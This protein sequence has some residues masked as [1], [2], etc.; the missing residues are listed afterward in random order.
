[1]VETYPEQ[2]GV[3]FRHYAAKGQ[4]QSE[5]A[6]RSALAAARQG[7]GWEMLEMACTNADRLTEAGLRSM[8][9]QLRLDVDRFVS[10]LAAVEVADVL[11][12]DER[13]A[14]TAQVTAVPAL[15][16][17]GTRLPDASTFD[18][19]DAAIKSAIK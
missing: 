5:L 18:A 14:A 10:D 3:S 12:S 13:D 15:F 1:V 16:V 7:K 11:A 9:V 19:I 17:N 2:V 8:A 4:A 6:Y